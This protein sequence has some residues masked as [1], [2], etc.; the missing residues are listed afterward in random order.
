MSYTIKLYQNHQNGTVQCYLCKRKQINDPQISGT[1]SKIAKY[2]KYGYSD[3]YLIWRNKMTA[4]RI[5]LYWCSDCD[6]PKCF[7][8][9][10]LLTL[11]VC[12]LVDGVFIC[13]ICHPDHIKNRDISYLSEDLSN[14]F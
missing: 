3:Y 13:A 1:Y 14:R 7:K 6:K 10:K 11:H 4:L 12:E 8:C 5:L 2:N 9:H